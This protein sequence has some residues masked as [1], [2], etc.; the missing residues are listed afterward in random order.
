M[1][2]IVFIISMLI[3]LSGQSQP[4]DKF[5]KNERSKVVEAMTPANN[6]PLLKRKIKLPF[7]NSEKEYFVRKEGHYFILN[8]DI[9]VG[10]D[11]PRTMSYTIS[12]GDYKWP[13]GAIPI[14]I[15]PS[16]YYA[17]LSGNVLQGIKEFNSKTELCLLNHAGEKD[18]IKIVYQDIDAGG[19]SY[20][21]RQGG[22]Q[23]LILSKNSSVRTV[24]HE[25]M[26]AAGF[27][28][29]HS[30]ED[31]DKYININFDNIKED[32]KDNFQTEGG[33]SIGNY[34]YC[35]IMHYSSNAFAKEGAGP[36]ITCKTDDK[37]CTEC[38]GNATTFSSQDI[39]NI[40]LFYDK[41]NRL[42]C[43]TTFTEQ[44]RKDYLFPTT[45]ISESDRAQHIFRHRATYASQN[46][47]AGG[48]P[49]F[50]ESRKG[51]DL[52]GG[53]VLLKKG[54][55]LW[56]DL[57]LKLLGAVDL[58]DFGGRMRATHDYAVRNGFV[59][60]FP[61]FFHENYGRGIVCGTILLKSDVA[62]W[63]DVPLSELGN[64][65][66]DDIGA[67]MRTAHEYAVRNG[68]LGGFPN[69]YHEDYGKGIVCGI[70]LIKRQAGIWR[71]VITLRGPR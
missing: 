58:S 11:L 12:G 1:K 71:E 9:I 22:E 6:T 26:H 47:F 48:L 32:K 40:N 34:D 59:G 25:L 41:I 4:T 18:F 56:R 38:L 67:R 50:H 19:R 49:T 14:V 55:A 39:S 63:R 17:G 42:P 69:F 7:S 54:F 64:P 44:P 36:T 15:D 68:Y 28:H 10:S 5:K 30:R 13:G 29:E 60:G 31:R 57:P 46:G 23:I 61:N 21:G 45:G 16:I 52:A 35:S 62:V 27:Y 70:I 24:I 65:A 51:I 20:V 53:T 66:L 37:A 43:R 3:Y 33:K 2:V 8:D